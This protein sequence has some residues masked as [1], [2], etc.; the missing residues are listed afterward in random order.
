[1]VKRATEVIEKDDDKLIAAIK[2]AV[3]KVMAPLT[4]KEPPEPEPAETAAADVTPSA[5]PAATLTAEE[6]ESSGSVL[7]W[8]ALGITGAVAVAGAAVLGAGG[9]DFSAMD[10]ET[11]GTPDWRDLKDTSETKVTAGA[12][13]LGVAGAAAIATIVIFVLDGGDEPAAS[14]GATATTNAM[15]TMGTRNEGVLDMAALIVTRSRSSD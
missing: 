14:A 15:T 3:A 4:G 10:D 8:V 12:V 2:Q 9:A 5:A 6:R 7:P 11:K 1:M 13:L